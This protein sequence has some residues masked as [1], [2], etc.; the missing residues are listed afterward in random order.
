[1][2]KRIH[3]LL[4]DYQDIAAAR[5]GNRSVK[6]IRWPILGPE[7]TGS[8]PQT[9]SMAMRHQENPV[10]SEQAHA[11]TDDKNCNHQ[12][13]GGWRGMTI[14]G[15]QTDSARHL[16]QDKTRSD[17]SLHVYEHIN[18]VA[19]RWHALTLAIYEHQCCDTNDVNDLIY[20]WDNG[21]DPDSLILDAAASFALEVQWRRLLSHAGAKFDGPSIVRLGDTVALRYVAYPLVLSAT[22]IVVSLPT[23]TENAYRCSHDMDAA[24]SVASFTADISPATLTR[25]ELE[26]ARWVSEGKTSPEVA[27]IL[28]LS[29]YTVNDYIRSGMKKM[30]ATNRLSFIAKTIRQGLVA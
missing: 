4:R 13:L 16:E 14:S 1:M 27:I 9:F 29:E 26:I 30:G 15:S 11:D 22:Y 23:D 17:A 2:P 5:L 8:P 19:R 3:T 7:G 28:S 24:L 20:G 18:G 21:G 12:L 10:P 6:P 25:R